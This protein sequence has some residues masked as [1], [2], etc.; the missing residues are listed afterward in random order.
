MRIA[1]CIDD[2]GGMLF[3]RRRQSQ[4]RL[5]RQDL[6]SEAAG[7]PLWM[8]PYSLGQF[9]GA[10]EQ[11]RGAEDF[12]SRAAAGE[13]CFFEDVDPAPWLERAEEVILYRWNRT[14][15]AD[16]R[17]PLPLTGWTLERREEFA[18]S[19]HEKITKEVYRR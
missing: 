13:L 11:V 16:R 2:R 9:S 4:D 10:P 18:G 17:F 15:P 5:L 3:N 6:L 1:V 14:Y 19:S 7:G 12:P 8:S